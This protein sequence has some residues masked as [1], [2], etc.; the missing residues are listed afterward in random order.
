M[1]RAGELTLRVAVAAALAV[2]CVVHLQLADA[3]QLAAPGG[4]GGGALFRGQAIAAGL[5]A[6]LLLATRRRFAYVVAGLVA[7]SAFVPVLLYTYVAVPAIG[8]IP[9]MYDPTWSDKKIVSALAEG[10]AVLLA[11]VGS[12][13]AR[14]PS[15]SSRTRPR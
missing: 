5:A 10:L 14:R 8:P 11:A 6:V 9:S 3:I 4:I 1:S 12:V 2:D 7:L 15:V 13:V